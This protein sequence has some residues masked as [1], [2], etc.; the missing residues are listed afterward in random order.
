MKSDITKSDITKKSLKA[1][2][3]L[4]LSYSWILTL[5][6]N[7]F[8]FEEMDGS[9]LREVAQEAGEQIKE[10]FGEIDLTREAVTSRVA[11]EKDLYKAGGYSKAHKLIK[12]AR[13]NF[14]GAPGEAFDL[15]KFRLVPIE[16][17]PNPRNSLEEIAGNMETLILPEGS[18]V[19]FLAHQ[20]VYTSL[21]QDEKKKRLN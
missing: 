3:A 17:T 19:G 18:K 9:D 5:L 7:I 11:F 2:I 16:S 4:I 20:P 13:A 6:S 15:S 8:K 21:E 12:D 1:R 14:P 10:T